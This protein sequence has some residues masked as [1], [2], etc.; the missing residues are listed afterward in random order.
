MFKVLMRNYIWAPAS[1]SGKNG[2]WYVVLKI[3]I[4]VRDH[5]YDHLRCRK[6]AILSSVISPAPEMRLISRSFLLMAR[7]VSAEEW[8][9][10]RGDDGSG[11]TE[12]LRLIFI[13]IMDTD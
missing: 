8:L 4:Q 5:N 1:C 11:R 10:F 7:A 3:I 13:K 6:S 12:D 9:I 2:C